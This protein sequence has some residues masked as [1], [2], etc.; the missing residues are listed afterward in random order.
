MGLGCAA[1][2]SAHLPA[3]A[4]TRGMS[5]DAPGATLSTGPQNE[6]PSASTTR[7]PSLTRSQREHH[8]RPCTQCPL[9]KE[10]KL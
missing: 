5:D 8:S 6:L 2:G 1:R 10:R 3:L 9:E 4:P 7:N